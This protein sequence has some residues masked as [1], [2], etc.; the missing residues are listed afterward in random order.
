MEPLRILIV[1][2]EEE[3]VSTLGER[4][5]LRGF[6]IESATSGEDALRLVGKNDFN[7]LIVDVKMPG[8]D[9]LE[10]TASVKHDKPELPVILLTGHGSVGE[11]E[12]GMRVGA[13]EYVMK[14]IDIDA[15]IE[16]IL[17]AAA[18]KEGRLS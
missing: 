1:D 3:L 10:L 6:Q 14:P 17:N 18:R 2:D 9:G 5:A 16:K 15:L 12:R 4:L 7:V 8:I 13:F 11:A